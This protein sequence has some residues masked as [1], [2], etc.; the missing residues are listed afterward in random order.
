MKRRNRILLMAMLTGIWLCVQSPF[1]HAQRMQAE[2]G[3]PHQA[4][5]TVMEA[6]PC[7]GDHHSAPADP[8]SEA[9][10]H[11]TAD[12]DSGGCCTGEHC[13][14]QCAHIIGALAAPASQLFVRGTAWLA[15]IDSAGLQR[16]HQPEPFR[17]PI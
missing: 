3:A 10:T 6:S 14:G 17:P 15:P 11:P 16:V 8:D 5:Q 2:A 4:V 1:A 12:S 9:T 13:D 7:H